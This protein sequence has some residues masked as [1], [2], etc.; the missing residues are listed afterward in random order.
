MSS[1]AVVTTYSSAAIDT[2]GADRLAVCLVQITDDDK[3]YSGMTGSNVTWTLNAQFAS[4]SGLDQTLIAQSAPV[5]S[6]LSVTAGSETYAGAEEWQN[7]TFALLPEASSTEASAAWVK[8]PMSKSIEFPGTAGN[9][10]EHTINEQHQG[11]GRGDDD[12]G[13]CQ[14]A[15]ANGSGSR[16]SSRDPVGRTS[17]RWDARRRKR[18]PLLLRHRFREAGTR[19]S[20]SSRPTHGSCSPITRPAGS[21]QTIRGHQ[22]HLRWRNRPRR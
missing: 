20:K 16:S 4:A 3:T 9:R 21:A 2:T 18:R 5:A 6:A 19:R 14:D 1:G 13:R 22:N 15:G 11:S 12:P 17:C 10:Y 8:N 7:Y